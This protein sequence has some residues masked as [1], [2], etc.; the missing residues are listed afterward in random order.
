MG[1]SKSA[2]LL[3]TAYSFEKRGIPFLCIKPS[4]DNRDG[5][6]VISS[7]IGIKREC[8][9]VLPTDDLY[10]VV[11]DYT[12]L[13]VDGY[14]LQPLKWILVDESQ[15]LSVCQVDQLADVVDR[16]GIDVICYG[17]RTDFRTRLFE[18]SMRLMEIA[19]DIEEI[20]I[21]CDCGRKA[22]FN[23][24]MDASGYIVTDGEQIVIGGDD[25]YRPLCRKCYNDAM[26]VVAGR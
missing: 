19:D 20:K 10:Q 21:S 18:G 25:I 15:F 9:T 6:D 13:S 14:L 8:V 26:R 11:V 2:Q 16:L 3:M 24:R 23:A 12:E 5:D 4:I 7:R 17:L 1:S 22:V